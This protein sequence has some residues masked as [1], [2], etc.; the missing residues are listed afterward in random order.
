MKFLVL[1]T[2]VLTTICHGAAHEYIS[3]YTST[4]RGFEIL[5]HSIPY[6]IASKD[7]GHNTF[8]CIIADETLLKKL[9]RD[10][11]EQVITKMGGSRDPSLF[12]SILFKFHEKYLDKDDLSAGISSVRMALF[13]I[14]TPGTVFVMRQPQTPAL[15]TTYAQK[16]SY[17]TL[18]RSKK[19]VLLN[20]ISASAASA[21]SESQTKNDDS[22]RLEEFAKQEHIRMLL[23]RGETETVAKLTKEFLEK[24]QTEKRNNVD[25][26]LKL[27]P[28]PNIDDCCLL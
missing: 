26:V 10:F 2:F 25:F 19:T 12:K 23:A 28:K 11:A 8:T 13:I 9:P 27:N 17:I 18:T 4:K 21:C 6:K 7:I 3:T 20:S 15:G 14:S 5:H 22:H 24:S 16:C 1:C